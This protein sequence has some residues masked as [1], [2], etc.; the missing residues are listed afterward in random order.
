MTK[1]YPRSFHC[2][3]RT[4]E[5][6]NELAALFGGNKSEVIRMSVDRMWHQEIGN[7][8]QMQREAKEDALAEDAKD[9]AEAMAREVAEHD[10]QSEREGW[11]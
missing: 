3:P 10:A 8:R 1:R 5:Q 2:G 7:E 11:Y 4:V 9:E 6:I